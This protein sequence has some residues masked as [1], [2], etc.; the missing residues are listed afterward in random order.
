MAVLNWF[1]YAT[2][3]GK[4]RMAIDI[5]LGGGISPRHARKHGR[6]SAVRL[7]HDPHV[8]AKVYREGRKVYANTNG[9]ETHPLQQNLESPASQPHRILR[10]EASRSLVI[11]LNI[12]S[13]PNDNALH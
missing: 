2:D 12:K 1:V 8:P 13:K 6:T 9:P 4:T 11:K 3:Y 7:A 10:G 5:H